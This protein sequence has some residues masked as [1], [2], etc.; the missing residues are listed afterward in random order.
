VF[1]AGVIGAVLSYQYRV[2]LVITA[3]GHDV[4]GRRERPTTKGLL[5]FAMNRAKCVIGVSEEMSQVTRECS[6]HPE[7]VVTMA[8]AVDTDRFSPNADGRVLRQRL[9]IRDED[10]LI[11]VLRRLALKTG[12]HLLLDALP[13]VKGQGVDYKVLLVGDGPERKN[14]EEQARQK[15]LNGKVIFAGNVDNAL[16]PEYIAACDF[17]VFPSLVE[18][19]SIAALEVMACGKPVVASNVGGLPEIIEDGET[20]LLVDFG[21][22]GADYGR[23][24]VPDS[25]IHGLSSAIAGIVNERQR[26]KLLGA[27]ARDRVLKDFSWEGYVGKLT[28]LYKG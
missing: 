15:G 19:T 18:A 20:G 14:L 1:P 13:E 11:L 27:K 28:N 2:P 3:H 6:P 8:N 12:I 25:V 23:R 24:K 21:G 17:A 26:C 4:I 22:I 9:G 7:R 10:V 5:S 16:V